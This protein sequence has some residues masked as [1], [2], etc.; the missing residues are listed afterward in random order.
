MEEEEQLGGFLVADQ[1]DFGCQEGGDLCFCLEDVS[2][3][4]QVKTL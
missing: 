2:A 3:G 4:W 1:R